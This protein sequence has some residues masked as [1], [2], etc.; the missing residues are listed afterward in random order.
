MFYV[1][2]FL[3]VFSIILL[4]TDYKNKYS[5]FF[6]IMVVGIIISLFSIMLH[7][8]VLGNYYYGIGNVFR[9]DY[10][11]FIKVSRKFKIPLSANGR[12]MNAGISLFLL[13]V[14]LFAYEFKKNSLN[15]TIFYKKNMFKIFMLILFPIFYILFYDPS[16]ALKFY[17]IYHS[18]NGN[19]SIIKFINILH[20]INK[21]FILFYLFY[22]IL[23]I[24]YLLQKK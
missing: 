19:M 7:I 14:P 17:L 20:N 1:I 18:K 22:P 3:A 4:L 21:L 15:D 23:Y 6:F 16:T 9:L 11:I 5:W 10:N 12:I 8:S 13:S 24:I 2:I